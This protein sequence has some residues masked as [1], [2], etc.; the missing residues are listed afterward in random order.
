MV[1]LTGEKAGLSL[2]SS[3][4]KTVLTA[5]RQLIKRWGSDQ[6]EVHFITFPSNY[7]VWFYGGRLIWEAGEG[8]KT[9]HNEVNGANAKVRINHGKSGA[10][11][12]LQ[13]VE[14][15]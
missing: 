12:V 7:V 13:G 9:A 2:S 5:A 4:H 1:P 10:G 6:C 14:G 11:I 8:G 15:M 3:S